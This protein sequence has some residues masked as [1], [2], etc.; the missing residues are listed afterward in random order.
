MSNHIHLL[1]GETDKPLN[2]FMKKLGTSYSYR[3]NQKYERVGHLFQDRYKSEPVSDD[4]YFLTVFRYIHQNPGKAGLTAFNW[5]SY[6]DYA[7]GR[8]ITDTDFALSLFRSSEELLNFLKEETDERCMEFEE[9]NRMTDERAAEMIC[10]IAKIKQGQ[11]LQSKEIKE[12]NR[13]IKELKASGLS[14]RQIERLTGMNRG[15]V[16]RA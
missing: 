12:R 4:S 1:V 9:E 15:I 7:Q 5:T 14:I 3:F 2:E 11:D 13:V 10:R 6:Q 16:F 8:G